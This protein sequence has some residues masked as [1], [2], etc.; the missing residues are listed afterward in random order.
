MN[1]PNIATFSFSVSQEAKVVSDAQ[2]TVTTKTNAILKGLKDLGIE[3]KDIK[4]SEYSVYPKYT[5]QSYPCSNINCPPSGQVAD[6]YTVSESI[7]VKVRKTEDAGKALAVAGDNGA[8]NI[9]SL[10]LT[11]DDP[12]APQDSARLAA[13][14]N[15]RTKADALAKHLGVK[16]VRVVSFSD[17]GQGYPIYPMAY[18]VKAMGT[19]GSVAPSIPVGE[20]KTTANVTVT[21]EIR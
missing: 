9:S 14:D 3:D 21:Y 10:Q 4:T 16:I 19:S 8:T 13:I 7:N 18:D 17:N 2:S 5:Y 11:L 1:V 6:G 12:N 20:N 15:A